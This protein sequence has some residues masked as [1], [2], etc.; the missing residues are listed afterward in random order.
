MMLLVRS[1]SAEF[2]EPFLD[3]DKSH[4]I[5]LARVRGRFRCGHRFGI[6]SHH[7]R[8]PD[9]VEVARHRVARLA[10]VPR[11]NGF[12]DGLVIPDATWDD[13]PPSACGCEFPARCRTRSARATASRKSTPAC[14]SPSLR[15]APRGNGGPTCRPHG[16]ARVPSASWQALRQAARS[17]VSDRAAAAIAAI[18][19]SISWRASRFSNGP[20]PSSA[21]TSGVSCRLI[22]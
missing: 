9:I 17:S 4:R 18:C 19:G 8:I 11:L 7:Q 13:S 3:R 12:E 1:R 15:P 10:R 16:P 6:R 5:F 14:R 21:C 22:T 20:K 2:A